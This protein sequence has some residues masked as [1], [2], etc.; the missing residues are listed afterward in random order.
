M[1]SGGV[2]VRNL[3]REYQTIQDFLMMEY[4]NT[5]KNI[6]NGFFASKLLTHDIVR[7]KWAITD[8]SYGTEFFRGQDHVHERPLIAPGNDDLSDKNWSYFKYYPKHSG[9]VGTESSLQD[10]D[11][12]ADWVL[13]RNA[14]MQQ[15]EGCQLQIVVPGDST[16]RIGSVVN[17]VIP[18]F[19]S[20]RNE[21]VDWLDK[22]MSGKYI[23]SAISHRLVSAQGYTMKLELTRDSLPSALPDSKITSIR[24]WPSQGDYFSQVVKA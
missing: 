11:R 15:I 16:L 21:Y 24:D 3:Q 23:V 6:E 13:K 4:H 9:L 1:D 18:S 7:K 10:N 19:E 2:G 17:M 22:Y 8:Y 14:Q 20:K 12:Y 5:M